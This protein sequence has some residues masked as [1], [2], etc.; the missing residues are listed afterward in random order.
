[1]DV[2]SVGA[3]T[4]TRD[5]H[6]SDH[7]ELCPGALPSPGRLLPQE[8]GASLHR[9]HLHTTTIGRAL[10]RAVVVVD[11]SQTWHAGT[12]GGDQTMSLHSWLS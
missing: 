10:Q 6:S 8:A 12:N 4:M 5:E 7:T 2:I 11:L 1:M 9:P 3:D